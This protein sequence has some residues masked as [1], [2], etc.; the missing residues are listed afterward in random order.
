MAETDCKTIL[1]TRTDEDNEKI[2]LVRERLH[3][4]NVNL[5]KSEN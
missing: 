2:E 3:L 1:I 5:I 4:A